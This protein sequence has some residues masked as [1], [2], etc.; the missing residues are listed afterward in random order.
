MFKF[1]KEPE[2]QAIVVNSAAEL[3][4]EERDLQLKK[5]SQLDYVAWLL[6]HLC[7]TA[8][9]G[10]LEIEQ[11]RSHLKDN[12]H[13]SGIKSAATVH[14]DVRTPAGESKLPRHGA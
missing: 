8:T 5:I 1:T 4:A 14:G 2:Q 10:N 7:W 11:F 12:Y 3:T 13:A 6:E 9:P